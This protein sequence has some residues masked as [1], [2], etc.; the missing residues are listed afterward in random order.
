[1]T[2]LRWGERTYVMGILNLTADSFSGDGLAPEGRSAEAVLSAAL[3]QADGFVAAG[4]DILDVG[5]ESSRPA[6]FYGQHP[7]LSAAD[8]SALAVP[9]VAALAE[10]F[11]AE[12]LLSIDTT[13]GE[14][15]RAAL[16]AGAAIVNDVWSGRRDPDTLRAA[17]EAGSY[18][19]LMHNAEVAEYPRG[20]FDEVV[21]WLSDA[22]AAALAA[23]IDRDRLIVDPGIGFGKTP[24]HSIELLHRL[25]EL[26]G[27][28]G[29]LPLLVG[30]SRKRFIGELLGGAPPD[31]RLEGTAAT[32]SL[33]IA[34]GAD[35]VRVHDVEPMMRT[36]RVTDGIVRWTASRR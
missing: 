8:E 14:V 27:A 6:Q 7:T 12:T 20:V 36:V 15:A 2:A 18:M 1:M 23:G 28:L 35:I 22:I 32:V 31:A 33:A 11:G 30:T 34:Q 4:A 21:A 16:G 29:G 10:R 25:G 24:E 9:V 13:K 3:A 5:A 26:K 17:A 19:V